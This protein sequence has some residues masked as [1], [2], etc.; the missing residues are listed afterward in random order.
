MA[1]VAPFPYTTFH[2]ANDAP[3]ANG[4]LSIRLNVDGNVDT[5]SG[6]L[7]LCS[8]IEVKIPL[9][10]FGIVNGNLNVWPNADITPSGTYYV[11]SVYSAKGDLVLGPSIVTVA[12]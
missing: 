1:T 11:Y 5:G 12:A 2:A 6:T 4:L 9:N 3:I 8:G 7:Q 10:Q